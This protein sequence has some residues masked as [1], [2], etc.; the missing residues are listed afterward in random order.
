M[1]SH[2]HPKCV[3][4]PCN[5]IF[6][7]QLH[8]LIVRAKTGGVIS[9]PFISN[10]TSNPLVPYSMLPHGC[11][12]TALSHRQ[13]SGLRSAVSPSSPVTST[14]YSQHSNYNRNVDT[15]GKRQVLMLLTHKVWP[16]TVSLLPFYSPGTSLALALIPH[17]LIPREKETTE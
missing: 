6:I 13:I 5:P 15:G 12:H 11:R 3:H 7:K 1:T 14:I 16:Y 2:T 8:F 17:H 10:A 9:A 4:S